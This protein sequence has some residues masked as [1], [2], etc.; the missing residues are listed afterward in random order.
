MISVVIVN[1]NTSAVL[2]KQLGGLK[3]SGEMEIIVVD[4]KSSDFTGS[5]LKDFPQIKFLINKENFGYARACNQGARKSRGKWL[6]FLNPDVSIT[7]KE[8]QNLIEIANRKQLDAFSPETEDQSYKKPLPS[9]LSL[10]AEFTP[11][12]YIIPL[13]IFPKKTLT[14]GA[15]FIKKEVFKK[16]G[17]WDE[18][19]FLWFE[20]S[21]LSKRLYDGGFS[22]G[23][24]K[25]DIEH[26]GGESF[27]QLDENKKR[28][29][30]FSSMDVY[31]QKNLSLWGKVIV[32][33][34]LFRFTTG[35]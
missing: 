28:K 9:G 5:L 8:I 1:W 19:F 15:L 12:K 24:I 6:V 4:N 26:V 7:A 25:S 20:D 17:G 29:I 13:M 16:L 22:V 32:K 10:L 33:F 3:T 21:D 14:G 34:L 23:W 2:K 18:R 35:D 27:R 11:L 31:A 30:F